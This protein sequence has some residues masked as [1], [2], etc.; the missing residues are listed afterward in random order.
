MP[1]RHASIRPVQVLTWAGIA[2]AALLVVAIAVLALVDWNRFREPLARYASEKSGY[3]VRIDGDLKVHLLSFTPSASAAGVSVSNPRWGERSR[4]LAFDAGTVE[5]KLLPLLIGRVIVERLT[6]TRPHVDLY[7]DESGRANWQA[8]RRAAPEQRA[9]RPPD[10]PLVRRFVIE[11]GVIRADDLKHRLSVRGTIAAAERSSGGDARP[12]RLAA[13]GTLNRAPFRLTVQGGPLVNLDPGEPYTFD[14]QVRA[15]ETQVAGTGTLPEPFD[16]KKIRVIAAMTGDDLADLY[17]L[18]GVALPNSRPYRLAARVEVNGTTIAIPAIDGRVGG[19]DLGGRGTIDLA[20]ER[21]RLTAD[22]VSKELDLGDLAA[23]LGVGLGD[24][25]PTGAD[26]DRDERPADP[27]R[28]LLPDLDLQVERVRALDARVSY[29]A[30]SVIARRVPFRDVRLGVDLDDGVLLVDPLA[31]SFDP[32]RLRG[33]VRIDARQDVPRSAVDLRITGV[34]LGKVQFRKAKAGA[35][36]A[37]RE[38]DARHSKS[39]GR[40]GPQEPPLEGVLQGR[41]RLTGS[42]ASVRKFAS[43]ADGGITFVVPKGQVNHAFAELTGINVARGLGLL[44]KDP[45]EQTTLRCAVADFGVRNGTVQARN[46]LFDTDVVR[47][48][49]R[50]KVDLGRERLDLA[51]QGKPKKVSVTRLRTPIEI[52]G[53]FADPRF[54]VD[55]GRLAA[56]GGVAAALGAVLAPLAAIFAFVDPGLAKDANCSA[57]LGE[58]GARGAPVQTR[59]AE[60]GAAS[61]RGGG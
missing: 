32:G 55:A 15:G 31:L 48:A 8:A 47:I 18:T 7:M 30:E 35:K 46:V 28:R 60:R 9:A 38:G 23:P 40:G 29:R 16:L 51:I 10:L 11:G 43:N 53:T 59:T 21:P 25:S 33:T 12:F 20:G 41:I 22:L 44:M 37:R 24:G 5:V 39:E 45:E 27:N 19:S 52:Q 13:N 58:A 6:I 49:G 54:G 56:Q 2:V 36:G 17:F 26:G 57:L 1:D 42:G 3:V 61:S 4:L 34:E 50:G 14:A